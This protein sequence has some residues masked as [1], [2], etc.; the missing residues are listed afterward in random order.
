MVVSSV[1]PLTD[2]AIL[3]HL[4]LS[5]SKRVRSR[6]RK[7]FHSAGSSS[8]A[9]GT[10]PAFSYCMPRST[11]MVASPPSSRIML[12]GLSGSGQVSI[13]SAAHQYSS[14]VS[15]FHA[16]TGTPLGSSGVPCGPTTTA[17]AA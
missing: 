4:S 12:A 11:N 10:T 1:T 16:N 17:A 5:V 2:S 15:P 14:S 3:V 8:S 9:G 13:C 6:F 7:T